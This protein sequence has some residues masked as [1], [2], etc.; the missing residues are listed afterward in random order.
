[1]TFPAQLFNNHV[2][3]LEQ[4]EYEEQGVSWEQVTFS[5]NQDMLELIEKK[6]IGILSILDEETKFPK[7]CAAHTNAA[8]AH[9]LVCRSLRLRPP[10][11]RF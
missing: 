4:K 11:C 9:T 6:P 2:F 7:V 1:M 5:D 8:C 3:K 10:T